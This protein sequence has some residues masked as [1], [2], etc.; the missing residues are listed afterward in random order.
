MSGLKFEWDPEKARSNLAKHKVSF[1]EAATAFADENGKVIPSPD[2]T[3]EEDRF[4]L[5]GFSLAN[6]L[7]IVVHCFRTEQL[8]IRIISARKASPNERKQY[9]R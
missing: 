1:E 9:G 6:R 4:V 7:L 2:H 5:L 3:D 8:T